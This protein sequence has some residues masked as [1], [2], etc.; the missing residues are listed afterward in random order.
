MIRPKSDE[1]GFT[2][3]ELMI[4]TAVFAVVLLI[5]TTGMIQVGRLYHKG[6]VNA[7][8]QEVARTI[9]EDISQAIQFGG[10]KAYLPGGPA[11]WFCVGSRRYT[12][13]RGVRLTNTPAN[14]VLVADRTSSTCNSATGAG[15]LGN[16]N[17]SVNR[18]L[19][20]QPRELM[21]FNMRLANLAI[22]A[23][24]NET[25]TITVR[26]VY[27]ENDVVCSPAQSTDC[28]SKTTSPFQTATDLACKDDR[29][30]TQFCSASQLTT[31][32]T[33]RVE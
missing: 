5:I 29:S 22:V 31:T 25:Y 12:Y 30:T 10:N 16:P 27:G 1:T 17:I 18:D 4:A 23:G 9:L 8:T 3:V 26:V 6:T 33:R 2:I 19:T 20:V 32:V 11:N 21:G 28:A 15:N 13:T 14:H 7:N 24:P